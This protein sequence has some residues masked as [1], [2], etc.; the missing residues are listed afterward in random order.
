MSSFQNR[1]LSDQNPYDPNAQKGTHYGPIGDAL[2]RA[3]ATDRPYRDPLFLHGI[4]HA[5]AAISRVG[6]SYLAAEVLDDNNITI[7][8]LEMAKVDNLDLIELREAVERHQA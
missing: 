8:E 4:A 5:L 6:H 3:L 1:R 2:M 7:A